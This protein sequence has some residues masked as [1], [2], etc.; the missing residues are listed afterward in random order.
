MITTIRKLKFVNKNVGKIVNFGF[1]VTNKFLLRN[2]AA[3]M[4]RKSF[5][6]TK[7]P[8]QFGPHFV[9][10]AMSWLANIKDKTAFLAASSTR[11][12]YNINKEPH[13]WV[14]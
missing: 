9:A 10:P 12:Y 13:Q 14:K 2:A 7:D 11:K 1:N 5:Q 3:L 4:I 8:E 6:F